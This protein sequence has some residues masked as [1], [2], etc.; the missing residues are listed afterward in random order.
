LGVEGEWVAINLNGEI[1]AE[2]PRIAADSGAEN[3]LK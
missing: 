3:Q 1:P 2:T